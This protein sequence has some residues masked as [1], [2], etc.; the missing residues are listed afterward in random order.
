MWMVPLIGIAG[1]A[2]FVGYGI[3]M[4]KKVK[5]MQAVLL[6][7][8]ISEEDQVSANS[9]ARKI[10]I[11][12]VAII[13]VSVIVILVALTGGSGSGK[14]DAG[15]CEFCGRYFAPGDKAG[16]FKNIARTGMCKNCYNNYQ[17]GKDYIGK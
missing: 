1:G 17:W 7:R 3:V 2:G 13:I 6:T 10:L 15:T 11:A 14:A 9:A 4:M 5:C 16:N 8:D 12:S